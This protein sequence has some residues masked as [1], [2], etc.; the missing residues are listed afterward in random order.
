[1]EAAAYVG[2]QAG[3]H[4][5]YSEEI[6][7]KTNKVIAKLS[8]SKSASYTKLGRDLV[9]IT[10]LTE[11]I[12]ALKEEVKLHT[13]EKIAD[14]FHASDAART[15]VV[16]TVGF[17]FQMTKDIESTTTYK[18][19]EILEELE[20]HLTPELIK[21]LSEIKGKFETTKSGSIG[22]LTAVQDKNVTP[23]EPTAESVMTEGVWDNVKAYFKK[24]Y[25]LVARWGQKYD[26]KLNALK[27]K[28]ETLG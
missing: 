4:V 25:D 5:S 18:Y 23:P 20:S 9:K 7:G 26:T 21:I 24:F 10:E 27:A 8:H 2:P 1:M 12:D 3:E 6:K 28:A 15:R 13:K 16:E 17:T 19:K 11:E 22:R 14:L